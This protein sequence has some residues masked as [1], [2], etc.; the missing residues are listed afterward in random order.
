MSAN[1]WFHQTVEEVQ[2][3]RGRTSL[4]SFVG[5]FAFVLSSR[6]KVSLGSLYVQR[7]PAV[8]HSPARGWPW[9]G[10]PISREPFALVSSRST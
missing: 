10:T 5:A 8:L 2:F 6:D 4:R 3:Y 7:G 9:R 1:A